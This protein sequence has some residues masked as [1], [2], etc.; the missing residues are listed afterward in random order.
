MI[1]GGMA[2][3]KFLTTKERL[4]KAERRNKELLERVE[5]LT[6]ALIEVAEIVA[7]KEEDDG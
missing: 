7:Q 2:L 4:R 1:Y 6:D 5:E 3:F